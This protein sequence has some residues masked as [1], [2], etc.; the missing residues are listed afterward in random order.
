MFDTKFGYVFL[1]PPNLG[2]RRIFLQVGKR[3]SE[4]TNIVGR[5]ELNPHTKQWVFGVSIAAS[6]IPSPKQIENLTNWANQHIPR[7]RKK[8]VKKL[9]EKENED[10]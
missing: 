1:I 3:D 7:S 8:L 10:N 5:I 6:F 9:L 2:K 4:Y